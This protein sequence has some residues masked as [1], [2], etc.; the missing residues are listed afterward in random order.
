M[1]TILADH[2]IE[3][4]A[5]M[6]WGTLA[7]EGW[8]ELLQIHLSMLAHEGL[9]HDSSD[10]K[11]WRFAQ[12]NRMILLTANRRMKGEDSLEQTIREEN[13]TDALPVLT[14]G[15]INHIQERTY[16]ERCALSGNRPY[17]YSMIDK[18]YTNPHFDCEKIQPQRTRRST[19]RK[20]FA[21]K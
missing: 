16:R 20:C 6:L 3:G 10:R 18:E 13:T 21:G 7:T 19:E 4:Q 2:N 14:I 11:I 1:L 15:S 5:T 12:K 9:P 17:F 8:T